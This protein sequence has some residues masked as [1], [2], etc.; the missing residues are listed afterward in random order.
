MLSGLSI[1]CGCFHAPMG[2]LSNCN[3]IHIRTS[4]SHFVLKSIKCL[5]SAALQKRFAAMP[6][7]YYIY[8]CIHMSVYKIYICTHTCV[9]I[10]CVWVCIYIIIIICIPSYDAN[11]L[12]AG[13]QLFNTLFFSKNR[14]GCDHGLQSQV[15][16]S[17]IWVSPYKLCTLREFIWPLCT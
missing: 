7:P 16:W 9:Y 8:I 17:W 15:A 11:I 12:R 6:M 5:L 2:Q 13:T 3:K 1:A 14:K 10:M 4:V